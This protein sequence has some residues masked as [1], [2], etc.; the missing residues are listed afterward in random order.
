MLKITDSQFIAMAE[1]I[2]TY[3]SMIV[4]VLENIE[5]GEKFIS[6]RW[7]SKLGS[8]ISMVI[9]GGNVIE[10]GGV[11]I[12]NVGGTNLPKSA[13]ESRPDLIGKSWKATGISIVIHPL[14]PHA[15]TCHANFRIFKLD[16]Q[17]WFGG[18]YDL[19]PYYPNE[20]DCRYWHSEAYKACKPFGAKLY[21]QLKADCDSYFYLPHRN[22]TRGIGGLFFDN[23]VL[24]SYE[25]TIKFIDTLVHCWL[26]SYSHIIAKRRNTVYNSRCRQFQLYRRGRYVEFNLLYDRGTLFGIQSG[27]RTESILMSLPPSVNWHYNF[28]LTKKERESIGKYFI[29]REWLKNTP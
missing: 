6:D 7:K 23:F 20:D 14:N 27:G 1:K 17:A 29:P 19:T 13:S 16:N 4:G 28:E 11:N 9:Q 18:G 3:Q 5:S 12:S 26:N 15:P 25:K 21:P 22:E 24:E 2:E 10:K 8:G